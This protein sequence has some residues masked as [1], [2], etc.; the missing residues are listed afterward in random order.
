MVKLKLDHKKKIINQE[1]PSYASKP[2]AFASPMSGDG[3]L[4]CP[5]NLL[6]EMENLTTLSFRN[7]VIETS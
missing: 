3:D 1:S 2:L 7:H 5:N 6:S 4:Q